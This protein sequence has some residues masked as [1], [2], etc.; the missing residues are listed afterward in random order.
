MTTAGDDEF[1]WSRLLL[2]VNSMCWFVVGAFSVVADLF[3]LDPEDRVPG[4]AILAPIGI[5]ACGLALAAIGGR[6]A[7]AVSVVLGGLVSAGAVW[8]L[9]DAGPTE[10][11]TSRFAIVFFVVV[12]CVS[13]TGAAAVAVG[14]R[15]LLAAGADP[16]RAG[17]SISQ[18]RR[19]RLMARLRQ[20]ISWLIVGAL[21]AIAAGTGWWWYRSTVLAPQ[22]GQVADTQLHAAMQEMQRQIHGLRFTDAETSC[23]SG[24]D[25]YA[26]W[27]YDDAQTLMAYARDAGCT[28]NE[29]AI[30]NDDEADFLTCSTS[31]RRVI[32]TI[33]F[34]DSAPISGSMTMS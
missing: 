34:P 31:G 2:A 17:V 6:I 4:V 29:Q 9:A 19:V 3:A 8:Q 10:W 12:A 25:A 5:A 33:E 26:L 23:D 14:M 21:F 18:P 15:D 11:F 20:V 22:C 24:F 28:V 32:F 16:T 7:T 27:E 30:H 1:S 13:A